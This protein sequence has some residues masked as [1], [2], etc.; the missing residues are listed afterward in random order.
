[1]ADGGR[2]VA[3]ASESM[4]RGHQERLAPM[5]AE[6]MARAGQ[7]FGALDRVAVTIGPGSFTGLRVGLAF[8]KGLGVATGAPLIGIGTLAA[9]AETA[10]G[11]GPVAAL[12]D[13]RRGH[14]YVQAFDRGR[15]TTEPK[16]LPLDEAVATLSRLPRWP[17]PVVG[18][19]AALMGPAAGAARVAEFAAPTLEALARLARRGGPTSDTRPLYLRAPDARPAPP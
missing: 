19:G 8:A 7:V 3:G 18:P 14:V 1:M 10:V 11:D 12:I 15:A 13:A 16:I 4:E 17:F 5:A 9:L 2:L 6:V